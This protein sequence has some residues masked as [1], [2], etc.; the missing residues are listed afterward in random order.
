MSEKQRQVAHFQAQPEG[1]EPFFHL[2]A[3]SVAY[4]EQPNYTPS[5]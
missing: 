1:L 2:A 5:A 3:L 4:L